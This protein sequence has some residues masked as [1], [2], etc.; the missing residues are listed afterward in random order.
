[1]ISNQD[2]A[3]SSI[4]GAR[5][6]WG[7]ILITTKKGSKGKPVVSYDNS[8]AWSSPMNTP[9][10]ADGALGVEY[11]LAGHRRTAPNQSDFNILG[12]YYDDLSIERMRQWKQLYG[13]K[14][15]GDEMVLGRDY[16][17][18]NGHP[19]FYRT[20]DVDEVFLNSESFKQKHNLS[21]LIKLALTFVWLMQL[22]G[23]TNIGL[24][25]IVIL[26]RIRMVLSTE[27]L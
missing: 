20:W 19:Y 6:T 22:V 9:E 23:L 16:E 11:M 15:L 21:I 2:A 13:G 26:K 10:I 7:V 12:A 4:Y 14:D 3:S 5:G 17:I 8:F 24:T 1:M 27:F 25:F 18:R